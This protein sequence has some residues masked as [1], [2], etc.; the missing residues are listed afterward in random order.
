MSTAAGTPFHWRSLQGL[1]VREALERPVAGDDERGRL[2]SFLTGE[3]AKIGAI[4]VGDMLYDYWRMDPSAVEAIDFASS[5]DLSNIAAFS[6]YSEDVLS[7]TGASLEGS[8]ERLKGYVAERMAA[9]I[10][11]ETSAAEVTFPKAANQEGFDLLVN[12]DPFQVKCVG[13]R[14]A[15]LEHLEK[16]PDIPVLVN[17]DLRAAFEGHPDVFALDGL[18][19]D[20]VRDVT[21]STLDGAAELTDYEL[22]TAIVAVVVARYG[23]ALV[24]GR[25]GVKEMI[26]G[27]ATDIAVRSAGGQLGVS[28][29]A[30]ATA[31]IG[32]TGGWASIVIP[33]FGGIGAAAYSRKAADYLKEKVLCRAEAAQLQ[34]AVTDYC[35]DASAVLRRSIA[36]AED[37]AVRVDSALS[38]KSE[39]VIPLRET[40][41]SRFEIE[42]SFRKVQL[43]RLEEIGA[44]PLE[45]RSDVGGLRGGALDAVDAAA[46]AGIIPRNISEAT[47]RLEAAIS[48]YAKKLE[49]YLLR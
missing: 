2:T 24:K 26:L 30:A 12:G 44:A 32:I 43:G 29:A 8:V 3:S 33:L 40:W 49:R 36:E 4:T 7:R 34:Q 47:A 38:G 35:W 10:L 16:N 20:A 14:S 15:V 37:K 1:D 19:N 27:G 13:D 18:S 11:R 45:N 39:L 28:T 41:Q 21:E 23:L 42:S 6:S 17:D 46:L 25:T 22:S 31:L 5:A 48:A 9:D